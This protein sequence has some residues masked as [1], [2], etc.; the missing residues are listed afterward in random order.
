MTEAELAIRVALYMAE[1]T[2]VDRSPPES[3]QMI[4]L[5]IWVAVHLAVTTGAVL[6]ACLYVSLG[7][8]ALAGG[9]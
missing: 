9:V 5:A 8:C 2:G 3:P 7:R 1:T 6:G 4:E